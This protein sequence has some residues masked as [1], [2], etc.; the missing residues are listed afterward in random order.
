MK[1]KI[2][3]KGRLFQTINMIKS[4]LE[5]DSEFELIS[6]NIDGYKDI[7]VLYNHGVNGNSTYWIWNYSTLKKFVFNNVLSE[8]VVLIYSTENMLFFIGEWVLSVNS[9]ICVNISIKT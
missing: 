3:H 6:R 7:S 4:V 1:I 9:G 8:R 5:A 2:F